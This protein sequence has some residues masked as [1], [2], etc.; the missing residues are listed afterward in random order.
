MDDPVK[1]GIPVALTM[2]S[3]MNPETAWF[4][5]IPVTIIMKTDSIYVR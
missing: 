1:I 2:M 4:L 3:L 5:A